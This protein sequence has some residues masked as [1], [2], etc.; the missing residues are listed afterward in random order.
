MKKVPEGKAYAVQNG[1]KIDVYYQ[2]DGDEWEKKSYD[3]KDSK[4]LAD[5]LRQ[6]YNVLAGVKKVTAA[7]AMITTSS[8]MLPISIIRP[9]RPSG[10]KTA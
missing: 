8:S 9:T 5:Y 3:L 1:K 10:R 6:D 2:E 4:P 7:A